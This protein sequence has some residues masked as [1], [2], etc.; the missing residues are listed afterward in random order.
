MAFVLPSKSQVGALNPDL[1]KEWD[2][3]NRAV[4]VAE[5]AYNPPPPK[6]V[7]PDWS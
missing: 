1:E 7:M 4:D 5:V 6:P 3:S 2:S